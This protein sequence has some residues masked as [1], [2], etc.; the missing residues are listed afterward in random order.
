MYFMNK[1]NDIYFFGIT[2]FVNWN[3]VYI[4][5]LQVKTIN[6]LNHKYIN[7]YMKVKNSFIYNYTENIIL[8]LPNYIYIYTITCFIYI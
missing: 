1:R 7:I 6:K 4:N 8:G 5:E 3:S 2:Y